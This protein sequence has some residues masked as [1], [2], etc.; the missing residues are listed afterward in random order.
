VLVGWALDVE[1]LRRVDPALPP[2]VPNTALLTGMLGAAIV[3]HARGSRVARH[4]TT[5]VCGTSSIHDSPGASS[6]ANRP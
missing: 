5:L 1:V 3:L 4:T 2:M 6:D